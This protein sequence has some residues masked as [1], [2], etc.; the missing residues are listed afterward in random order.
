MKVLAWILL[1]LNVGWFLLCA[2]F[3]IFNGL[4]VLFV[5]L[6]VLVIGRKQ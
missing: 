3:G 1:S 6:S 2:H 5:C 4:A